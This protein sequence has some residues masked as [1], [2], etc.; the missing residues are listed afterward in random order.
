[1]KK[2]EVSGQALLADTLHLGVTGAIERQEA[3][4]QR[5]FTQSDT[6]PTRGLAD[7]ATSVGIRILGPVPD[8]KLFTRVHLPAGWTKRA[9]NH[10]MWSDLLDELGRIR[11]SIFYKAAF[12]DRSAHISFHQRFDIAPDAELKDKTGEVSWVVTDCEKVLYRTP[13]IS[14]GMLYGAP[15]YFEAAEPLDA[16]ARQQAI[17]WVS[18]RYPAW[19]S[20][21]AY[22]EAADTYT[23]TLVG[24]DAP[25]TFPTLGEAWSA[26]GKIARR[27]IVQ[28]CDADKLPGFKVVGADYGP[29][30][31]LLDSNKLPV[32]LNVTSSLPVPAPAPSA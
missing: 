1:M 5:Q 8:D 12:Y 16:K 19:K 25:A 31:Y 20:L 10:S 30:Y 2:D 15:G 9:T 6:L 7:I 26:M 4:G 23:M 32:W 21:S 17:D 24:E 14:P 18:V 22:W 28:G 3:D 27:L 13:P 29:R 11:A